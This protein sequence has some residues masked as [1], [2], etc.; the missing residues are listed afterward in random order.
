[1]IRLHGGTKILATLARSKQSCASTRKYPEDARAIQNVLSFRKRVRA[2]FHRL[3][4]ESEP[5]A[6]EVSIGEFRKSAGA[7]RWRTSC[8]SVSYARPHRGT[9][10][11]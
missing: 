2:E 6:L 10:P 8:P 5:L 3:V 11:I 1:M 7:R 4:R 9:A